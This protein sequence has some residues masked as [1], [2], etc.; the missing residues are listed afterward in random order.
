M[1]YEK[2]DALINKIPDEM[3][4]HVEDKIFIRVVLKMTQS[5]LKILDVDRLLDAS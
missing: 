1:Y 4:K 2:L 5:R 3:E